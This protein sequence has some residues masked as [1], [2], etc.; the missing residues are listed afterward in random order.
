MNLSVGMCFLLERSIEITSAPA[1]FKA[2]TQASPILP[3]APTTTEL[4]GFSKLT[5]KLYDPFDM[6][7]KILV[8]DIQFG[9]MASSSVI[10]A[11]IGTSGTA[12]R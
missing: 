7:R 9:T 6:L 4:W 2:V 12:C 5:F 10:A 1:R 11:G 3:F 8:I